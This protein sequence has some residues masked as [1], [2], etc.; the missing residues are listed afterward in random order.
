MVRRSVAVRRLWHCFTLSLLFGLIVTMAWIIH[1]IAMFLSVAWVII[2]MS[3]FRSFVINSLIAPIFVVILWLDILNRGRLVR[4]GRR[5]VR[6]VTIVHICTARHSMAIF[7]GSLGCFLCTTL[8]LFAIHSSCGI[9][10]VFVRRHSVARTDCGSGRRHVVSC[11][12]LR[13]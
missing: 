1:M 4:R 6:K 2:H 13:N 10:E 8:C 7:G 3:V 11:G 5:R 9:L 12:R